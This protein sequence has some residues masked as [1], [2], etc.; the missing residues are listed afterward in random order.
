MLSR[1]RPVGLRVTNARPNVTKRWKH[2][3]PNWQI[4]RT[5]AELLLQWTSPWEIENNES[6]SIFLE[7]VGYVVPNLVVLRW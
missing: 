2:T 1:C 6:V 5:S 3:V 4:L 7:E